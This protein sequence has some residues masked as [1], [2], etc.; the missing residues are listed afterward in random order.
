MKNKIA[1]CMMIVGIQVSSVA[2]AADDSGSSKGFKTYDSIS[3]YFP[4]GRIAQDLEPFPDGRE[5]PVEWIDHPDGVLHAKRCMQ[6]TTAMTKLSSSDL[7]ISL[8]DNCEQLDYAPSDLVRLR[9]AVLTPSSV[10]HGTDYSA[11]S[12]EAC[13]QIVTDM[14]PL[15]FTQ[16]NQIALEGHCDG[17][18]VKLTVFLAGSTR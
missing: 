16:D 3:V 15:E 9:V 8:I 11:D 7:K 17:N 6:F 14:G 12:A 13:Q 1:L 2:L 4:D 18:V 10:L 5:R